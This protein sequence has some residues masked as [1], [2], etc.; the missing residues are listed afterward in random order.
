[1]KLF[2]SVLLLFTVLIMA[3][4]TNSSPAASVPETTNATPVVY[5][6]TASSTTNVDKTGIRPMQKYYRPAGT[7]TGTVRI[8]IDKSDFELRVYDSKGLLAAYPV[9]FGLKPL[10]DKF[11]QGDRKTPEGSFKITYAKEHQLWRKM[12]MLDYPTTESMIKYKLRKKNGLIPANANVGNGI[13]IHGVERGNDYFIDR[14]YNWTNG[15]IS[16]KNTHIDD[17]ARYAQ[18]GTIVTIQK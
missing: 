6:S 4:S 5:K 17:L 9:V 1:M 3:C 12:L 14:Y 8:I 10:E 15:C 11:M 7:A 16:L 18:T 13:G 2:T